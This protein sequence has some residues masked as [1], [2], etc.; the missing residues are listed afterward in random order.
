MRTFSLQLIPLLCTLKVDD[1]YECSREL[2]FDYESEALDK[3]FIDVPDIAGMKKET[4]LCKQ[5]ATISLT[6]TTDDSGPGS[7]SSLH[8]LSITLRC[9]Y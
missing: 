5:S 4:K 7:D 6:R 9:I 1:F 2:D 8:S 3:K